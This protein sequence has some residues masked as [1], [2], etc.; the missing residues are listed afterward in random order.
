MTGTRGS[1]VSAAAGAAAAS[2][3]AGASAGA[4]AGRSAIAI[5]V[6]AVAWRTTSASSSDRR[7]FTASSSA[8]RVCIASRSAVATSVVASLGAGGRGTVDASAATCSLATRSRRSR[9]DASGFELPGENVTRCGFGAVSGTFGGDGTGALGG[10][11]AGAFAGDTAFGGDRSLSTALAFLS[12]SMAA[13]WA[14]A[15]A[16]LRSEARV[17]LAASSFFE[18]GSRRGVLDSSIDISRERV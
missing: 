14:Y 15:W 6:A 12:D 17:A 9:G 4:S 13:F 3:G 16:A 5:F 1:T 11:V 10:A 18:D 8:S 2:A 7:V